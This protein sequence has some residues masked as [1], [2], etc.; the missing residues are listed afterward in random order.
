M[1]VTSSKS[2]AHAVLVSPVFT[3]GK[4][5][6]VLL[7]EQELGSFTADAQSM[8]TIGSGTGFSG[9]P[10][11]DMG[12]RPGGMMPGSSSDSGSFGAD[13]ENRP[14]PPDGSAPDT[15]Q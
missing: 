1:T 8:A 7:N 14:T 9:R 2:Y 10:S 5:Y 13:F 11:G 6:T 12:G 3:D 4:T 15:A